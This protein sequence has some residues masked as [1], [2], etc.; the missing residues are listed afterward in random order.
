MCHAPASTEASCVI[1]GSQPRHVEARL[2]AAMARAGVPQHALDCY[3]AAIACT[4]ITAATRL[5]LPRSLGGSLPDTE[6]EADPGR[7][8]GRSLGGQGSS[9]AAVHGCQITAPR[10]PALGARNAGGAESARVADRE[11][12]RLTAE[13]YPMLVKELRRR[14]NRPTSPPDRIHP[15]G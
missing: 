10:R 1:W 4:A 2:R 9:D 5:A 14:Q 3:G 8:L 13:T 11:V 7:I 12:L 15:T 6:E